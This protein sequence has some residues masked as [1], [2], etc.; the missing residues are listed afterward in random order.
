M[1][2]WGSEEEDEM[3]IIRREHERRQEVV[4]GEREREEKAERIARGYR[5]TLAALGEDKDR[6]AQFLG[7]LRSVILLSIEGTEYL[8]VE[9]EVWGILV[10]RIALRLAEPCTAASN[11]SLNQQVVSQ[12]TK[13]IDKREKN[14]EEIKR[15][16]R[17]I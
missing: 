3:S 16:L 9:E 14:L 4:A 10:E 11:Q 12:L 8:E 15:Q 5:E 13:I 2:G 7:Y 1:E 17:G 6:L